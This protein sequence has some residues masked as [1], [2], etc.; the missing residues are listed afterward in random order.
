MAV[1]VRGTAVSEA[2]AGAASGVQAVGELA[3]GF[4]ND[5]RIG[6]TGL[7]VWPAYDND[8]R[9]AGYECRHTL[10]IFCPDLEKAG[11]LVSALGD[12]HGR[13]LIENVQPVIA[14]TAPLEVVA[15]ER[16][17]A[18]ARAK[19]DELAAL[20]GAEVAGVVTIVEEGA[21][22]QPIREVM[23]MAKADST[24]FEAGSQAVTAGLTVT[25]SL[26]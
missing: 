23:E 6:S 7:H 11:D 1:V 17:W 20:A 2:L 24:R 19:A 18:D 4:T 14:D 22:H 5:E 25:W 26:A 16:A 9:S 12:L 21:G 3:R 13:V 10:S 8:G 15:R